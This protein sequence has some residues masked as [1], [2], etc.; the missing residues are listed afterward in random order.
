MYFFRKIN[1]L[2]FCLTWSYL[3]LHCISSLILDI[4]NLSF[5]VK[6]W[7]LGPG[8][9][10]CLLYLLAKPFIAGALLKILSHQNFVH[11]N[12]VFKCYKY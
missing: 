5:S 7:N 6:T 9:S 11:W 2:S 3:T 8:L 10:R 12:G 4:L 1:E